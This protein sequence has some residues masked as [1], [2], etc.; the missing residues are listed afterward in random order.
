MEKNTVNASNAAEY[1]KKLKK[2]T[3]LIVLG[4]LTKFAD[5]SEALEG[6]KVKVSL[7]LSGV[8]GLSEI[9]ENEIE[10]YGWC[11][12]SKS[13]VSIVLPEGLRKIGDGAFANQKSLVS[14]KIPKSVKKIGTSAFENC[15]SL[16]SLELPDGI[17][18]ISRTLLQGCAA[19]KEITIP[20]NVTKINKNAF[21]G[22]TSLEKI[23]VDKNNKVFDSRESC[24]A[25]IE[26]ATNTLICGC[27]N[28]VI[29][30]EIEKIEQNAF[31][32]SFIKEINIPGKVSSISIEAFSN[33]TSLEKI[34]ISK[35]NKTYDSRENCNAI[36]ETATNTLILGC[37][38]TVIP[39]EIEKIGKFSFENSAIKE[40]NISASVKEISSDAYFGCFSIESIRVVEDN[41]VYDSRENC[42][43]IIETATNTLVH[44]CKNTV[45]PKSVKKIGMQAFAGDMSL[46]HITIPEGV[47]EIGE[48]AFCNCPLTEIYIPDSVKKVGDG[49]FINC[50]KME[51]IYLRKGIEK[52]CYSF[53]NPG[54]YI[55]RK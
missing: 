50:N 55:W 19:L 1:I 41:K 40:I 11:G 2:D 39:E 46:T 10:I 14:V 44:G 36:I 27:K 37:K 53:R 43:A 18:E 31:K 15:P 22:C 29:P 38:N 25:I 12:G 32:D 42:N 28:T 23:T 24:N 3:E 17:K 54:E 20:E 26:T 13:L 49:A 21:F 30:E 48:A 34:I 47:T 16:L 45:I 4:K 8:E 9:E 35:G 7:D 6:C 5:I 52:D 51:K 33:C